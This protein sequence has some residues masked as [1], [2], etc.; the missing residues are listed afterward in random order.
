MS[1]LPLDVN[2]QFMTIVAT[3]MPFVA[4][5]SMPHAVTDDGA[6]L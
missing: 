5:G 4:R 2:A 3:K 1:N 6:M